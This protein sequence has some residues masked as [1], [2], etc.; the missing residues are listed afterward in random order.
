M[1]RRPP[2][3]SGVSKGPRPDRPSGAR[4]DPRD[5]PFTGHDRRRGRR[6]LR[7]QGADAGTLLDPGVGP[8]RLDPQSRVRERT[9]RHGGTARDQDRERIRFEPDLHRSHQRD[10]RNRA[11]RARRRGARDHRY[12]LPGRPSALVPQ[13]RRIQ[14]ARTDQSGVYQVSSLPSGDYLAVATDDVEQGEW[15]DPEFLD[16]IRDKAMRVTLGE[17]DQRTQ[18]LKA[19]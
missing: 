16:R 13:S 10:Q 7:H 8:S 19:S 12:P 6:L 4:L 3:T 2:R 5:W 17:G 1:R 9:R 15:F 14:T 11:G 18:D